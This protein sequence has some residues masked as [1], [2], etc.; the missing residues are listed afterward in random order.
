MRRLF[1]PL[2]AAM[3]L[4][5]VGM[6]QTPPYTDNF[7]SY[8]LNGFIAAQ[9]GDWWT[10]WSNL[11]GSNEDGQ[12]SNAYS[13]SPTQAILLDE[14]N[15]AS[16]LIL[17][18]GDQVSGSYE[19]KW[20]MYVENGKC[21]YFNIQ[22]TMVPGTQWAYEAYLRTNG[23][24]ELYAG[25]QTAIPFSYPKATWF[26]VKNL[27]DFKTRKLTV[28][29]RWGKKVYSADPYNNDWDGGNQAAGVYYF[30]LE[31]DNGIKSGDK[32]GSFNIIR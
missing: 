3:L 9:N 5:S 8:T 27:M 4:S 17:K 13:N 14:V 26:E 31:Y 18:L 6:A 24:G 11:P 29:N 25:S 16:D 28:F 23:D 22:K 19:L 30:I 10:T 20:M 15:A 21:G 12:V 2:L 32:E 1:L 7:D